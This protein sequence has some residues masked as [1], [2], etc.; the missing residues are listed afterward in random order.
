MGAVRGLS[1][2][3]DAKRLNCW[4]KILQRQV[5][6]NG[7]IISDVINKQRI[8]QSSRGLLYD[9]ERDYLLSF[10]PW[11]KFP[12]NLFFILNDLSGVSQQRAFLI[13]WL[14]YSCWSAALWISGRRLKQML[15]G[16]LMCSSDTFNLSCD[17]AIW[18]HKSDRMS[19]RIRAPS[20]TYTAG[21]VLLQTH[22][23]FLCWP[24][25]PC[26]WATNYYRLHT[27]IIKANINVMNQH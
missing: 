17:K 15:N 23:L 4:A 10:P 27:L 25:S 22:L 16:C 8:F 13:L 24:S 2:P 11:L 3:W 19:F 1:P 26:C 6:Y 20:L 21:S 5:Y 9:S 14:R 12:S 7:Q 18:E